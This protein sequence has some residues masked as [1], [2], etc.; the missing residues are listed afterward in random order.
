M[1]PEYVKSEYLDSLIEQAIKEDVGEGDHST[2]SVIPYNKMGEAVLVAK[3]DGVIAGIE[4]AKIVYE[5]FDKN[6]TFIPNYKD[7]NMIRSGNVIFRLQGHARHILTSERLVLN[8]MQ[9][10]SGIATHTRDLCNLIS[11]TKTRLLDTRKTTPNLRAIEKWAVLIGGGENHRIGLYDMIMLK[12]NHIDFAGGIIQAL[13]AAKEYLIKNQLDLK[14]EV[15]TRNLDEIDQVLSSG[16][17]DIIMLDNMS[18]E[19][20]TKAVKLINGK[21]W[22][23]ASGNINKGNIREVAECKV[24]YISVGALT[25]SVKSLDLSL[26]TKI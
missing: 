7:G 3:E 23:E 24:D 18:I 21:C 6:L 25:H 8:F 13:K 22:V 16:L 4:L 1:I 17:A 9:R 19:D 15:E 11:H 2:L 5:R 20:M 10:M 26:K 14:I 12:D